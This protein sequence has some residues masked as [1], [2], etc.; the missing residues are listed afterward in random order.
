MAARTPHQHVYSLGMQ[1]V[2]DSSGE[3]D[4]DVSDFELEAGYPA[5]QSAAD[6]DEESSSSERGSESEPAVSIRLDDSDAKEEMSERAP[7]PS[8]P[9]SPSSSPS[10]LRLDSPVAAAAPRPAASPSPRPSPAPRRPPP[11][12]RAPAFNPAPSHF[13]RTRRGRSTVWSMADWAA[14]RGAVVAAEA[15]RLANERRW[16][17]NGGRGP[18]SRRRA[19]RRANARRARDARGRFVRL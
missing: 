8:P 11:A 2:H 4:G 5:I 17:I 19:W 14:Q 7:S 10:T 18:I 1:I 3:T 13:V 6:D 16:A 15:R 12:A 9:P